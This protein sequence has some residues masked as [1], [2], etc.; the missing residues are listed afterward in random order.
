MKDLSNQ[1]EE[2]ANM[3]PTVAACVRVYVS[4]RI[5]TLEPATEC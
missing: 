1:E 3:E 5:M 4:Y 2:W